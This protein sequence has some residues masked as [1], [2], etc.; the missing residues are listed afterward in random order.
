MAGES[1]NS[2]ALYVCLS[3]C[4]KSKCRGRFEKRETNAYEKRVRNDEE[5]QRVV[6]IE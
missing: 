5:N 6:L 3:S 4:A 1:S 2:I